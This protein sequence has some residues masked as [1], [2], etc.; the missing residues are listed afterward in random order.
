MAST[1]HETP[2]S[3]AISSLRYDPE[4]WQVV[5]TFRP[6]G[7]TTVV[8]GVSEI[9]FQEWLDSGSIGA[10]YNENYRRD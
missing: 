2:Q 7:K 3:S 9:E 8:D 10:H 1:T 4:T 5:V 6:T